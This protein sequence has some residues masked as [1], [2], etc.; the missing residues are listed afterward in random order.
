MNS[1][2]Y[3]NGT[4]QY[5]LKQFVFTV[6]RTGGVYGNSQLEDIKGVQNIVSWLRCF[7]VWHKD[8]TTLNFVNVSPLVQI[9]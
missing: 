3:G 7:Y 1:T 6:W 4:L 2:G 8:G 5:G 9:Q